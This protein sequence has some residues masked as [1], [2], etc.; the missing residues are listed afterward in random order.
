MARV[1]AVCSMRFGLR[2]PSLRRNI[3]G[4]ARSDRHPDGLAPDAV[5]CCHQAIEV[6][7]AARGRCPP[8]ST[9]VSICSML[10]RSGAKKFPSP[11]AGRLLC[12]RDHDAVGN[13]GPRWAGCGG[14]RRSY[15][16]D[17]WRGAARAATARSRAATDRRRTRARFRIARRRF[18][19]ACG[20]GD[21]AG[22]AGAGGRCTT[23]WPSPRRGGR[24][25]AGFC[26]SRANPRPRSSTR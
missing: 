23:R 22:N 18:R 25:S 14:H 16:G 12:Q 13:L 26:M 15:R 11:A 7:G 4:G 2:E 17:V 8:T 19:P 1:C 24:R 6:A 3:G 5:K 9:R 10:E 21:G 20:R